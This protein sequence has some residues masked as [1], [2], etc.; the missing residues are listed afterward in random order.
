MA[1]V[2]ITKRAVDAL[3]AQAKEAGRT[4]YAWDSDLTGFGMLATK[5]GSVSY[6]IEFRMGGRGTP[7]RRMSLGKHGAL[8][9][10][11]ARQIAKSKLGDVAKGRDVAQE[12]KDIRRKLAAGTF[13]DAV[14]RY[15]AAAGAGNRSWG[16]TRRLLE[17]DAIPALGNKPIV[18]VT[19]GDIAGLVDTVAARSPSVARALFAA[20]RPFFKWCRDRGLIE[21]NHIADLK[22]PAPIASRRRVLSVDKIKAFWTATAALDWPFCPVYR[23]LLLTGQRREEV[24]GLC[25]EE[26]DLSGAIWTLPAQRAK[27]GEEHLVDLAPQAIAI[28]EGLPGERSG[29]V[30]TTTG[31]T[32]VSG[33]AKAKQRLDTLIAN[34]SGRAPEPWRNHDLR[35]TMATQAAEV[36][37]IEP[38]VIERLLN[39]ISGSQGGLKGIYQRQAY[40]QKRREAMLAWGAFVERLVAGG[41]KSGNV[42]QFHRVASAAE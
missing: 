29:L 21:V 24:A 13:K 37:D 33:F 40:R 31:D 38:D 36:L 3:A 12:R 11:Q 2:K 30:F 20:V 1:T 10:D 9:P 18:T 23:L 5:A 14:E 39:H 34:A 17:H 4:L 15:L 26:I 35:R 41:D 28:L 22:G 19:R 6:F 25:W 27:N 8:T 16:E 7:N 32:P 42:V